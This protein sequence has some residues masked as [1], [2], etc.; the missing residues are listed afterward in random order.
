MRKPVYAICKQQR[1]RSACASPQSGQRL[2]FRL[3][4]SIISRRPVFVVSG[5]KPPK[6]GFL[7]TRLKCRGKGGCWLRV[8]LWDNADHMPPTNKMGIIPIHKQNNIV[9][10][11][12]ARRVLYL[13]SIF[14]M[15]NTFTSFLS[16]PPPPVPPTPATHKWY[17]IQVS[18]CPYVCVS[19]LFLIC[20]F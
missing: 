3:L 19:T 4:D 6:T 17:T 1:R 9:M 18:V 11:L 12:S 5:C 8:P 2:C 7:M 10:N 15:N 16:R 20:N 13:S 14:S